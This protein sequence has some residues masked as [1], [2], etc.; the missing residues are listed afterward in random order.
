MS[1]IHIKGIPIWNGKTFQI[2][3]NEHWVEEELIRETLKYSEN[4]LSYALDSVHKLQAALGNLP[5]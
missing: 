5:S 4:V 3:Q 1:Q 2:C